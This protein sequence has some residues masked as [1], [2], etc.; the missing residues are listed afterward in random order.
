[1]QIGFCTIM[2][3]MPGEFQPRSWIAE[4]LGTAGLAQVFVE[5]AIRAIDTCAW[6]RIPGVAR[7]LDENG[8]EIKSRINRYLRLSPLG[9]YSLLARS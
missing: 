5:I 3:Y 4:S 2:A 7:L 9:S 8:R 6:R 1:M